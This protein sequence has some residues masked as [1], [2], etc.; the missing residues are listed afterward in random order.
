MAYTAL[1]EIVKRISSHAVKF[2]AP[3]ETEILLQNEKGE[4]L[5]Y[6]ILTG[7]IEIIR[8]S[9]QLLI[10]IVCKPTVLG[11]F[12]TK[13][14]VESNCKIILRRNCSGLY[15]TLEQA[16]DVI[17][18]YQLW[19]QVF[20]WM[21]FQNYFLIQAYDS[22]AGRGSYYQIR[23]ALL[24]MA[25]WDEPLRSSVKVGAYIQRRTNLSR[26]IISSVLAELR[27]G[28]YI[29]MINGRLLSVNKL[30]ANY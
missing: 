11:L 21:N 14:H 13:N 1:K 2:C 4:K 19:R 24:H 15:I 27:R 23:T 25:E 9:D 30:P 10:D 22:I 26:S 17:E 8:D 3:Q 5:V 12:D 18:K 20:I 7:A 16:M 6:F 29:K 28:D